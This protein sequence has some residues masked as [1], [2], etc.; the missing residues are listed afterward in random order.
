[1]SEFTLKNT[2]REKERETKKET[3]SSSIERERERV[4]STFHHKP[5][6]HAGAFLFAP[7][8]LLSVLSLSL[9]LSLSLSFS[10]SL[11]TPTHTLS[12]THRHIRGAPFSSCTKP[13]RGTSALQKR[14]FPIKNRGQTNNYR[15]KTLQ[16]E[17]VQSGVSSCCR[18]SKCMR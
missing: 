1:M 2:N 5:L 9:Y 18:S 4:P 6:L 8:P 16:G 3:E 17:H 12:H 11:P 15:Y 7:I 10:P 13:R 14:H